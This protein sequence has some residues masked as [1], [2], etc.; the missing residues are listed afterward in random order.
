MAKSIRLKNDYYWDASSIA[1]K[2]IK[3][4]KNL[5]DFITPGIYKGYE[6][7]TNTYSNRPVNTGPFILE[8]FKTPEG[9]VCQRY[10]Q[11]RENNTDRSNVSQ[12]T[13]MRFYT[14]NWSRWQGEASAVTY[15]T[16]SGN[17]GWYRI[18]RASYLGGWANTSAIITIKSGSAGPMNLNGSIRF[19]QYH[20]SA[21][22]VQIIEGNITPSRVKVILNSDDNTFDVFVLTSSMYVTLDIFYQISSHNWVEINPSYFGTEDKLPTASN[23]YEVFPPEYCYRAGQTYEITGYTALSGFLT[24]SKTS[25][26]F[27]LPVAKSL[28]FITSIT[29][30]SYNLDIR[31]ADG[32]YIGTGITSVAGK[33]VANKRSDNLIE[34]TI[35]LD[36]ATSFTNNSTIAVGVNA[37]KLTFN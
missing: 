9:V 15:E 23:T 27:S 7:S 37:L 5:N 8:V 34:I 26:Q 30:N 28:E 13:F 36:S 35:T 10:T 6:V 22:S 1:V 4:G 24:S 2:T 25:I 16:T 18:F 19:T 21:P 33:I 31:H 17:Y 3:S 11:C 12:G 20:T 14:T 32:G 29:I